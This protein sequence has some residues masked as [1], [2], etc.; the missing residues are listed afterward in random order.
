MVF[1][2]LACGTLVTDTAFYTCP[3]TVP[4]PTVTTLPGT[5]IPTL[6]LPPTPFTLAPPQDFYVGD[7]V[8][9]GQPGAALRAHGHRAA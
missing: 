3:T 5:P 9:V 1:A 6:A 8:F 7:A 4:V 2:A